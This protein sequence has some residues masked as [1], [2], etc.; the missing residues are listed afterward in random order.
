V[1][2]GKLQLKHAPAT[3]KRDINKAKNVMRCRDSR[4]AKSRET[5]RD[6]S[7][8]QFSMLSPLPCFLAFA[9]LLSLH[10]LTFLVLLLMEAE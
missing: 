10:L 9:D 8:K 6:D 5:S 3:D 7:M 4:S 2:D 1:I